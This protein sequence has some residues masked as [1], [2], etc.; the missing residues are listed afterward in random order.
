MSA[1]HRIGH[2]SCLVIM[3]TLSSF[4]LQAACD[5]S[6]S[7]K[8]LTHFFP[9]HPFSTSRKHSVENL[10]VNIRKPYGFLKFS[11]GIERCIGNKWVN[12]L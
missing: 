4:F 11:G 7:S 9:M 6:Y 5:H 8:E 3:V 12:V 10:K 2:M 1:D